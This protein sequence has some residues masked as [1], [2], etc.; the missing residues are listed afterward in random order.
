MKMANIKT[1]CNDLLYKLEH[2]MFY[3]SF[4]IYKLVQADWLIYDQLYV[5]SH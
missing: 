1:S 4:N 3:Y 5:I 2:Q